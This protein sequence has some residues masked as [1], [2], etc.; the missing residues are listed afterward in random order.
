MP[1]AI[2]QQSDALMLAAS[3]L[4]GPESYNEEE[5][6]SVLAD[7]LLA[8][9]PGLVRMRYDVE[10]QGMDGYGLIAAIAAKRGYVR[11]GGTPYLD[12]AARALLQDYRSGLLGR[13]TLETPQSR[14]AMLAKSAK[15]S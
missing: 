6:A 14:S 12:K 9:Y 15:S 8:R 5:V 4:I 11:K 2:A 13:V 3:H 1:P 10:P 7:V